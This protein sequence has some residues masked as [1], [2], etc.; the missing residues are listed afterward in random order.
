MYDVITVGSATVDVFAHTE[1]ELITIKTSHGKEE[2]IAYPSGSKILI[3]RLEFKIGGGGT[4]TAVSFSHLG[5]KTAYLGKIGN[6]ENGEKV[7]KL[8]KKEKIDFVG[9]KAKN[10]QVIQ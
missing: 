6:D 7:L 10:K 8:L 1:S 3:D 2:L 4:N 5:L 9:V